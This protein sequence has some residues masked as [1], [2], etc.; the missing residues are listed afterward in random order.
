MENVFVTLNLPASFRR[1]GA[2]TVGIGITLLWVFALGAQTFAMALFASSVI[3]LFETQKY[4]NRTQ[5][6]DEAAVDKAIGAAYAS[7][8]ALSV[9]PTF[10]LASIGIAIAIALFW[11][12]DTRAPSTVGWLRRRLANGF[13]LVLSTLLAGIASGLGGALFVSLVA[14]I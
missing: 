11:Y 5:S 14:N 4:F 1:I 8:I 13:G 6:L 10:A 7:Y 9:A 3:A 2:V 12:F